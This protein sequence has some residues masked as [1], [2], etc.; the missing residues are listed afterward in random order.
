MTYAFLGA[1][2]THNVRIFSRDRINGRRRSNVPTWD[3]PRGVPKDPD[4]RR[5]LAQVHIVEQGLLWHCCRTY[6]NTEPLTVQMSIT[7]GVFFT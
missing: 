6:N 2:C 1:F 3:G 5:F 4:V 7:E